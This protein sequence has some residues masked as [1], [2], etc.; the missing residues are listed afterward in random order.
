MQLKTDKI[1]AFQENV[2]PSGAKLA[3]LAALVR[4]LSVQAPVRRPSSRVKALIIAA[5][6]VARFA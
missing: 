1:T 3:G 6:I 4:A 2:L 5:S